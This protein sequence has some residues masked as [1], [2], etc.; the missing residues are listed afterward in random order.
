MAKKTD[1]RLTDAKQKVSDLQE[2]VATFAK[3]AEK[4]PGSAEIRS[5]LVKVQRDLAD[6]EQA[7]ADVQ[8]QIAR[9]TFDA[10]INALRQEVHLLQ[11]TMSEIALAMAQA[12]DDAALEEQLA[13]TRKQRD[14]RLQQI[15]NMQLA[16]EAASRRDVQAETAAKE[17]RL[18]QLQEQHAAA[19]SKTIQQATQLMD[20]LAAAGPQWAA[21]LAHLSEANA[22]GR[23]MVLLARGKDA[24]NRVF[25]R[26]GADG[27]FH[28]A[29]G[30]RSALASTRI[31]IDGPQLYGVTIPYVTAKELTGASDLERYLRRAFETQREAIGPEPEQTARVAPDDARHVDSGF[32]RPAEARRV[33]RDIQHW[34]PVPL[35]HLQAQDEVGF[36]FAAKKA[37]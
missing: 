2:K 17:R 5:Q 24:C 22:L 6:A 33:H 11:E 14:A 23:E 3:A 37:K 8:A 10:R 30:I 1:S 35:D 9:E 36:R 31:G 21:T 25:G 34:P 29:S 7:M 20:H 26:A 27:H 28:L 18:A 15:E 12:P 32:A 13:D 4:A 16:M 19:W